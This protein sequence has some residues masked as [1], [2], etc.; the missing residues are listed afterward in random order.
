M[1]PQDFLYA[2]THCSYQSK[3]QTDEVMEGQMFDGHSALPLYRI[4]EVKRRI[5]SYK[6]R[7]PLFLSAL[8]CS[9]QI[10]FQ[11]ASRNATQS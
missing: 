9:S 7:L 4:Q 10:R 3:L 6:V 5:E 2:L 8:I 11:T 1:I